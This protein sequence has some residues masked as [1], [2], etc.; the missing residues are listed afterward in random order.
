[1][2]RSDNR[3][4]AERC[5]ATA[6]EDS[7][8]AEALFRA[9]L[10]APACFHAQQAAEK[11][12]KA[13]WHLADA[14]PWGHSVKRLVTEFPRKGEIE[15]LEGLSEKAGLLDQFY[16]PTRYPNGLP[17]LTPGQVYGE[18]DAQRA[19]DTAKKFV[20]LCEDWLRKSEQLT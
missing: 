17:D 11:A 19:M 4:Q 13:M 15:D 6:K 5:W 8:A 9:D 2:S 20:A 14:D 7:S 16:V 12:M 3:Y 18:M 10:F 1:M